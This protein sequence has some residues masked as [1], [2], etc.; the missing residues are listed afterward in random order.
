MVLYEVKRKWLCDGIVEAY[1]IITLCKQCV[2]IS[3]IYKLINHRVH[4][5]PVST[6]WCLLGLCLYFLVAARPICKIVPV[7]FKVTL[8]TGYQI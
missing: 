4:D 8:F 6:S 3:S 1:R 7:T 5:S 2:T